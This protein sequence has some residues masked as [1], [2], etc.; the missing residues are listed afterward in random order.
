MDSRGEKRDIGCIA[1][2]MLICRH[3]LCIEDPFQLGYNV[4]RT[5]TK[6]GLYTIRG[7]FMRASRILSNHH[8]IVRADRVQASLDELCEEREDGLTRAPEGYR[9]RQQHGGFNNFGYSVDPR[10]LHPRGRHHYEGL[11][12][13]GFGGSF[14][15]EEMARSLGQAQRN[16]IAYPPT[17]AMLAPLSQ[18]TGLSPRQTVMRAGLRFDA[19]TRQPAG[20]SPSTLVPSSARSDD[21]GGSADS[22]H[23]QVVSRTTTNASARTS[24]S[25]SYTLPHRHHHEQDQ[26]HDDEEDAKSVMGDSFAL[27]SEI[28]FGS[29]RFQ[30]HPHPESCTSSSPSS[31]SVISASARAQ[32]LA[33]EQQAS[34]RAESSGHGNANAI[35]DSLLPPG[36]DG[37]GQRTSRSFSDGVNRSMSLPRPIIDP[38]EAHRRAS[39]PL[40]SEPPSPKAASAT[41][42]RFLGLHH[43]ARHPMQSQPSLR[44]YPANVP[45]ALG[46]SPGSSGVHGLQPAMA[47]LSVN[48]NQMSHCNL[49][50]S[51]NGH[52]AP[53][54]TRRTS[55]R[56]NS[57]S[58]QADASSPLRTASDVVVASAGP[59][60]GGEGSIVGHGQSPYL[61]HSSWSFL[62]PSSATMYTDPTQN[63]L[64]SSY[65]TPGVIPGSRDSIEGIE[66]VSD[67]FVLDDE[68]DGAASISDGTLDELARVSALEADGVDSPTLPSE[69]KKRHRLPAAPRRSPSHHLRTGGNGNDHAAVR[70][71][72][73]QQSQRMEQEKIGKAPVRTVAN[74]TS[75]PSL[76]PTS[77]P[78]FSSALS[79]VMMAKSLSSANS[80]PPHAVLLPNLGEADGFAG[81]DEN[82]KHTQD[83]EEDL[84]DTTAVMSSPT[85]SKSKAFLEM[86]DYVIDDDERTPTAP[87]RSFTKQ[88]RKP[89]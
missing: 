81:L 3:Q 89:S 79:P 64:Y 61:S 56:S 45:H 87:V 84:G 49:P 27:G 75:S 59:G 52:M 68:D 67:R 17:T 66:S 12:S 36:A 10:T 43:H 60:G 85:A 2:A 54:Q 76:P 16:P 51:A 22:F 39:I 48:N 20:S 5:V 13:S 34:Y 47:S 23:H 14:A 30:L 21:G 33:L 74:D 1:R 25:L 55:P 31:S 6:D 83:D 32:L 18:S 88:Q 19:R 69:Q 71:W 26:Q 53:H 37:P 57:V 82:A 41:K 40:R 72:A 63:I 28:S 73:V 42:P 38:A 86:S 24:P 7:E 80:S 15:F 29:E 78:T 58:S 9:P 65:T 46:Y 11:M 8:N 50:P 70:S 35:E 62:Q 4:S 77:S 44:H